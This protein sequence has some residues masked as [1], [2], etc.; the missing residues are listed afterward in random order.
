[1]DTDMT[2]YV[3][4]KRSLIPWIIVM[5][6][7][8]VVVFAQTSQDALA[9][10][11]RRIAEKRSQVESLSN[12]LELTKTDYNE[13]LRSLATQKADVETQIKREQLRLQQIEQDLEEYQASI[14]QNEAVLDDLE[15]LLAQVLERTRSYIENGLPFQV[16]DRLSEL[17]TL[18]RLL[19]EGSLEADA[20]LARVWNTVES[21]FRLTTESGIYRQTIE[22]AGEPQLAE[23]ARLGMALMYFRTLDN[24]YGYAV[25]RDGEWEYRAAQGRDETQQIAE[26][27]DSLRRN[28][29][30]G[31]FELPNPLSRG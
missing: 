24:Q 8:P 5:I 14:Q 1:M 21:E 31:F 23:V 17:D 28:L 16:S 3:R 29:R 15:P 18:E 4:R 22:L 10:L 9:N 11:A 2:K 26:L 25:Q 30:E 20:L 27:F 12:E 19:Q 7:L 6:L 13:Q